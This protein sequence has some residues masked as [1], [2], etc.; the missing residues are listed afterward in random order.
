MYNIS[1]IHI[2]LVLESHVLPT[3]NFSTISGVN[4][5][6]FSCDN[7]CKYKRQRQRKWY[8]HICN[9]T[10]IFSYA[11]RTTAGAES[12]VNYFMPFLSNI[13][14]LI[15]QIE[16]IKPCN[17]YPCD[18]REGRSYDH[19]LQERATYNY[20]DPYAHDHYSPN[21]YLGRALAA[22]HPK[23]AK[24]PPP[25]SPGYNPYGKWVWSNM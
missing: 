20:V 13:C 19:K 15:C 4:Y 25:Y 16:R 21:P 23:P 2:I 14:K 3:S 8:R 11:P 6:T 1:V 10:N 9:C 18:C 5:L 17:R 22:Y 12:E 24:L 7:I